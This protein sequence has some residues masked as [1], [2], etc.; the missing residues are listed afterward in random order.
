MEINLIVIRSNQPKELSEFYEQL[1]LKFDYHRHGKGT[2]HYSTEI[3]ET[4]FEI[5]PLMKHQEIPDKSL[6][7]G[8]TVDN[9]D[10]LI[11]T[12]KRKN[13]KIVRE[14]KK[15][16]WGYFAIIKDIDGRKIELKMK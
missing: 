16:E 15:S 9:L 10:E 4:V 7:L 12:L 1:G 14:P 8:F 11:T 13:H 3:G 2:W 5:Y 6:R